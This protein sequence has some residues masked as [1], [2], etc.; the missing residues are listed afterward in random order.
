MI[1]DFLNTVDSVLNLSNQIVDLT[2]WNTIVYSLN[3]SVDI[4]L[5]I[6]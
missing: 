4:I 2:E 1:V 6:S 5:E 3:H